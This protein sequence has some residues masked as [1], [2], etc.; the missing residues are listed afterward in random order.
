MDIGRIKSEDPD[1]SQ[2]RAERTSGEL[3][4]NIGLSLSVSLLEPLGSTES[5]C[6][7]ARAQRAF[8]SSKSE[9]DTNADDSVREAEEMSLVEATLTV[10]NDQHTHINCEP[11][12]LATVTYKNREHIDLTYELDDVKAEDF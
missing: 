6:N 10:G 1:G 11:R 3:K 9:P 2:V 8:T 4:P 5:N 12:V 7:L